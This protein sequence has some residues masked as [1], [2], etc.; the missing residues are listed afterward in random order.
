MSQRKKDE[1]YS[2]LNAALSHIQIA[3]ERIAELDTGGDARLKTGEIQRI[4][5]ILSEIEENIHQVKKVAI[6][7][8]SIAKK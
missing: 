1:M 6:D 3:A 7:F 8:E 5:G 2:A 4:R